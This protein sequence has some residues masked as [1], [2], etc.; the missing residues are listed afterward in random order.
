L[1]IEQIR[2]AIE[3]GRSAYHFESGWYVQYEPSNTHDWTAEASNART[4]PMGA[5]IGKAF[6]LPGFESAGQRV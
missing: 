3:G 1:T 5:D 6:K 4:I 2:G